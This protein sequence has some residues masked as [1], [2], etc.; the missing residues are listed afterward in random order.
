V[1]V[2]VRCPRCTSGHVAVTLVAWP[3]PGG[4]R[5]SA[6]LDEPATCS[7]GCALPP[8][9]VERL[10][11]RVYREWPVQLPLLGGAALS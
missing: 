6:W 9:E 1:T 11:Q 2:R 4:A 5:R 3:I 8:S 10:L 7:A